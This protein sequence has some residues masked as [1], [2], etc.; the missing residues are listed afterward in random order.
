MGIQTLAFTPM[1]KFPIRAEEVP[2]VIVIDVLELKF[3]GV[4]LPKEFP[5]FSASYEFDTKDVH[6]PG[7]LRVVVVPFHGP[8]K[9][10]IPLSEAHERFKIILC[11]YLTN[12]Q[13]SGGV[14]D[15]ERVLNTCH[16]LPPS[17]F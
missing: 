8:L 11:F 7:S 15:I 17:P 12:G 4:P 16:R 5:I 14:D 1:L 10:E 6:N 2:V 3:I 13:V 9:A